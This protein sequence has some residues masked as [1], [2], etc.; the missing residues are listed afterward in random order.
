MFHSIRIAGNAAVHE[1]KGTVA[2]RRKILYRNDDGYSTGA[3]TIEYY[4][5]DFLIKVLQSVTRKGWEYPRDILVE[6]TASYIGF[7]K[8]SEAFKERMK[9]VFRKAIRRNTLYR[10]GA[11]LGKN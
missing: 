3:P 8:V 6:D 7:D 2:V 9:S 1:G 5:D 4:E 10:N 11:Y